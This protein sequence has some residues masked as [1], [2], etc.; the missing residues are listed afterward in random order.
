[1]GIGWRCGEVVTIVEGPRLVVLG[2]PHE[3][4]YAR[5]VGGLQ[6]AQEGVLE[7]ARTETSPLLG[8]RHGKAP[9]T[10]TGTGWASP[11]FIRSAACS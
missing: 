7:E 11:F 4:A 8:D 1:M 5:E 9:S 3:G 10:M 6:R 2:M